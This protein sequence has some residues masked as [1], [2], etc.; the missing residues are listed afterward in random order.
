MAD[1]PKLYG[2]GTSV[3]AQREGRI[4]ILERAGGA[5]TGAWYTPGGVLDPGETPEECAVRE[6]FEETGLRP[7]GPLS[8]VGLIPMYVYGVDTFL[9]AYACDC[10]EGDVRLSEEHT[11][12][13]WIDADE[14]RERFFSDENVRRVNEAN[15]GLGRM[16]RAVRQGIDDY[17]TWRA[18]GRELESLRGRG[19]R[20]D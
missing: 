19:D 15:E 14:Y 20:G 7:S 4:L 16:A 3:Y 1:E 11:D 12:F 5:A 8:L 9:A 6:L 18:R 13:R 10:N 17:L 2:I